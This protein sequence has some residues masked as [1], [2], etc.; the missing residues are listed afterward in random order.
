M[1]TTKFQKVVFAFLSVIITVH[2]FVFY[3]LAI[4]MGGMS[5]QVFIASR[6]VIAIEF[7]FAFLLQIIIAGP[8]SL[9]LAFNF[10]NPREDKP[11][12]VT[13]AIICAT[14][15]LMCPMMSFVATILYN[16][17][18]IEFLAQWMQK[19]LGIPREHTICSSAAV[20]YI[21]KQ[22]SVPPRK[23]GIIHIE[24]LHALGCLRPLELIA[25]G[26]LYVI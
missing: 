9:K 6:K 24:I 12:V 17:I 10:V 15:G 18:T 19:M 21:A 23:E 8:L 2:L 4:E 16:G 20:G 25:G 5:N 3:N 11:Y 7:V 1:P 13:T 22:A 14:V 26:F